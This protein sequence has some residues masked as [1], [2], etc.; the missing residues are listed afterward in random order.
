MVKATGGGAFKF[1]DLFKEKL[2]I[3]LDKVEEM[4]SLVSGANFLL[5]VGFMLKASTMINLVSWD[6]W[7]V[8]VCILISCL[9]TT[10]ENLSNLKLHLKR[11][12]KK[13]LLLVIDL[14]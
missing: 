11:W 6:K 5:K 9:D 12:R 8:F 2:G 7:T 3:S 4:G 1:A 13:T 14:A 10:F